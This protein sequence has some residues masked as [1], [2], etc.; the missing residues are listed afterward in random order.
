MGY[1]GKF[2]TPQPLTASDIPDLAA[3]KITSGTL[4]DARFPAT[5]P[6]LNGSNLTNLDAADLTG[7]L[8]AISGANLTGI[9][10][11][12]VK[13]LTVDV[14]TAVSSIQFINGTNGVDF[15]STYK[16]F[17]F[18]IDGLEFSVDNARARMQ[19]GTSGSF[20]STSGDYSE[21]Q[22]TKT[23][24]SSISNTASTNAT[25][26]RLTSGGPDADDNGSSQNGTVTCYNFSNSTSRAMIYSV[27]V[28]NNL[29]S[30]GVGN[31]NLHFCTWCFEYTNGAVDRVQF[32]PD[33][34]NITDGSITMFGM[35][36]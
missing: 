1:I 2:P 34:G 23:G 33:S 14:S 31:N 18:H 22:I 13:L 24:G 28:A 26:C 15:S 19:F 25:S 29:D 9:A 21:V 5:L 12:F 17:M 36:A 27:G 11:D 16:A 35:K 10:S 20:R 32:I 4:A 3:S 6:A 7:T 8:P 30:G